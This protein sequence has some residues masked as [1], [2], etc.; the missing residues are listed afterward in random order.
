MVPGDGKGLTLCD[1]NLDGWL[2]WLSHKT[3][4]A[5][6]CL[7]IRQK[8]TTNLCIALKERGIPMGSG[9][10]E[11]LAEGS[12]GGTPRDLCRERLPQSINT[13]DLRATS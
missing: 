6:F 8:M 2:T 1:A 11:Y 10:A 3:T 4:I 13:T 7:K 5:C 9:A 12:Q